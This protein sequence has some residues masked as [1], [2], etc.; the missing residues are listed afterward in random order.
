MN[1][2]A[3]ILLIFPLITVS[4]DQNS[5]RYNLNNHYSCLSQQDREVIIEEIKENLKFLKNQKII[6]NNNQSVSFIWPIRKDTSLVFHNYFGISNFVDQDTTTGVILDYTC[7]DRS[8]DGH[9][10]TDIFTW[11]FP[12]YIYNN[13]YVDVIAAED[14]IIV[15]KH[16]GYDDDHCPNTMGGSWNAVY[17][18]HNDGSIVWYGH[19]K[20]NSLTSKMIGQSVVKGEYLG[21]LASSGYSSGPHLHLEIYDNSWNLID[22]F[23]GSC[24]TLNSNTW[25]TN[26]RNYR[27]PTLN[28]LLTHNSKPI[29][30]CP[31]INESPNISNNFIIGDTV[32]LAA[33]Y[34]DRELGDLANYRIKTPNNTLWDS[35]N[36]VSSTTYNASWYYWKRVLPQNGPFGTWLFEIEFNGQIYLHEFEYLTSVS[37]ENNKNKTKELICI[38]D[39]LGRKTKLNKNKILFFV[40]D[41]GTVEKKIIIN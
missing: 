17:I 2:L 1:K 11:P 21:K 41:D 26:Q 12:W 18:Q 34:A 32:F 13:D 14:G 24:N 35:W 25:W 27:E 37:I 22:P 23:E 29:H 33:Y 8:Y 36:Q 20:K 31:L 6:L 19:L 30:G 38:T 10:G 28:A 5:G 15:N 39:I 4:Q 40:Y 9:H 16:D 7:L 3:I